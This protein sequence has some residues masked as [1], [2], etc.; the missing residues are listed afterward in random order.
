MKY[1]TLNVN[2]YEWF[3]NMINGNLLGSEVD[4]VNKSYLLMFR[5]AKR[6]S[7]CSQCQGNWK[8]TYNND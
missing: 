4:M 6:V 3:Y 8:N 2:E 1:T 5:K 7:K